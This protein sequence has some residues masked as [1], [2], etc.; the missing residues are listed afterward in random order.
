MIPFFFLIFSC[1]PKE[2]EKKDTPPED[3]PRESNTAVDGSVLTLTKNQSGSDDKKSDKIK[4][5]EQKGDHEIIW[6]TFSGPLHLQS[7]KPTSYLLPESLMIGSLSDPLSYTLA[8]R[9][10]YSL[11]VKFW[12]NFRKG[13]IPGELLSRN[14]H[15]LFL[16]EMEEYLDKGSEVIALYPGSFRLL[17]SSASMKL[18][19]LSETGYLK[20]VMYMNN[21][22]D[23][24]SLEDWEIP[25]RDWPGETVPRDKDLL[26]R[27][28]VY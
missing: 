12:E 10:A 5:D 2:A 14:A 3:I 8:E 27:R 9:E 21:E 18:V 15:P 22:N 7:I 11:V 13:R 17:G 16:E 28:T 26:S 4:E 20:A 23:T 1:T 6:D 19:L 25:F 24:W